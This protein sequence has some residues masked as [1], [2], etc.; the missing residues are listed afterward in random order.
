MCMSTHEVSCRSFVL[1]VSERGFCQGLRPY[2]SQRS[3]S[4]L[5]L[6]AT[7]R[8]ELLI[9]VPLVGA[10]DSRF[11]IH[12]AEMPRNLLQLTSFSSVF[13]TRFQCGL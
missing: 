13:V 10:K 1:K 7:C 5:A 2:G 6:A 8:I 4:P 3:I 12:L 11:V 9:E